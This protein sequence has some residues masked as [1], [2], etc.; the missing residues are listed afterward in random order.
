MFLQRTIHRL[1]C[2]SNIIRQMEVFVADFIQHIF[3]LIS[4]QVVFSS[5]ELNQRILIHLSPLTGGF[6]LFLTSIVSL[7]CG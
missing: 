6:A 3:C 7:Q 5:Y 2:D 4:V 1:K